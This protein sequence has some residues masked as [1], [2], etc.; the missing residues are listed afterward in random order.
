MAGHGKRGGVAAQ[1]IKSYRPLERGDVKA[2][3]G[4]LARTPV[5]RRLK[6]RKKP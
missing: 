6:T 2:K 5:K 4:Q 3:P 1:I